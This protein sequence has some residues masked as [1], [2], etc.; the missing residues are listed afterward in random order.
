MVT[1]VLAKGT[2]RVGT[3]VQHGGVTLY[4]NVHCT[5]TV[6]YIR[7]LSHAT[8]QRPSDKRQHILMAC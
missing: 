5:D 4:V 3:E 8:L 6:D 1:P 7:Q 2:F